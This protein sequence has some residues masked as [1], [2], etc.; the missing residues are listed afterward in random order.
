MGAGRGD[1]LRGGNWPAASLREG[2]RLVVYAAISG[3]MGTAPK[4]GLGELLRD[5]TGEAGGL[6]ATRYQNE[7]TVGGRCN[8]TSRD[9]GTARLWT[10]LTRQAYMALSAVQHHNHREWT[11]AH[12]LCTTSGWQPHS[13]PLERVRST[14]LLTARYI[15]L[16][17]QI[18]SSSSHGRLALNIK[19]HSTFGR[20]VKA[21]VLGTNS[22][23][24]EFNPHSVQ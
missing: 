20:V 1:T 12:N 8:T 15:G 13:N 2:R 7:N 6:A 18:P 23:E 5:I 9:T 11:T 3:S 10:Q 24:R 16:E 4:P 19:N 22:K 14:T 21:L 17:L